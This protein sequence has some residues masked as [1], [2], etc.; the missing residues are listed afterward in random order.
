[1]KSRPILMSAPMVRAILDGSKTQTRRT[2][3]VTDTG[4]VKAVGSCKNWHLDDPNCIEA[5]P[6]GSV[7]DTLWVRETWC[8]E[9]DGVDFRFAYRADN[10]TECPNSD[11][12]WKPSIHMPRDAYRIALEITAVRVER[13]ND[14]SEED[15]IAEGCK[16]DSWDYPVSAKPSRSAYHTLWDSINGIGSFAE[17]PWVWVISFR[18]VKP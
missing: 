13:L 12:K 11:G 15:A 3:K 7:G 14:I 10:W 4:R 9:D 5:C 1:M 8:I 18:R 2:V 16:A 6:Y 17:N